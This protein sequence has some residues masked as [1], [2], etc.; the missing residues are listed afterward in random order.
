MPRVCQRCAG[1]LTL[2]LFPM[3]MED[4]MEDAMVPFV[5]EE[6]G[7]EVWRPRLSDLA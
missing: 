3:F 6:G 1:P 5:L 4:A 2:T 7:G